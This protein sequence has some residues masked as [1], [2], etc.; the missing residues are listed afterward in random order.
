VYHPSGETALPCY[1]IYCCE[2]SF[3]H[4]GLS[5][6]GLRHGDLHHIACW[7]RSSSSGDVLCVIGRLLSDY[8]VDH[9]EIDLLIAHHRGSCRIEQ[10]EDCFG[11]KIS[12][13]VGELVLCEDC[14][15]NQISLFV[16]TA[17][18]RSEQTGSTWAA[19]A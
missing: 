19:A 17:A 18:A 14:R 6:S 13:S 15:I 10:I 9:S 5:G 8:W 4:Q 7:I 1:Q 16:F 12:A 3:V 11:W 2:G